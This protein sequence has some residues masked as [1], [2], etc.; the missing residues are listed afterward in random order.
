MRWAFEMC[1][2]AWIERRETEELP[3]VERGAGPAGTSSWMTLQEYDSR[4]GE[5]EDREVQMNICERTAEPYIKLLD[6][7]HRD[8]PPGELAVRIRSQLRLADSLS[9]LPPPPDATV[10]L[11]LA[12]EILEN[13]ID[14]NLHPPCGCVPR[15]PAAPSGWTPRSIPREAIG[16]V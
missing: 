13:V 10:S 1:E 5:L 8:R 7:R 16:E 3:R 12:L 11:P 9:C 15:T 14:F 4:L 2:R 6:G